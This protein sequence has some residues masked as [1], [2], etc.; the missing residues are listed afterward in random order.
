M[1]DKGGRGQL[2]RQDAARAD[3]R[4]K[5]IQRREVAAKHDGISSWGYTGV[6]GNQKVGKRHD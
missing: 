2:A 3:W 5:Q 4:A 6:S 1:K